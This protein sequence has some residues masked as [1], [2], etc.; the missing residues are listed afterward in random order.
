MSFWSDWSDGKKWFM[1]MA[2]AV[3]LG[4][5]GWAG[6]TAISYFLGNET[7][8][9]VKLLSARP[10]Q[11]SFGDSNS[12]ITEIRRILA[13]PV[14]KSLQSSCFEDQS[15]LRGDFSVL[16]YQGS[17]GYANNFSLEDTNIGDADC[18]RDVLRGTRF[19][20]PTGGE[21]LDG[22]WISGRIEVGQ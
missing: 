18:V 5:I 16:I 3:I 8:T 15:G 14:A 19:P 10:A 21:E 20:E 17:N 9:Q 2:S 12:S 22:Y 6:S 4:G 13:G 11:T 7:S 1:G